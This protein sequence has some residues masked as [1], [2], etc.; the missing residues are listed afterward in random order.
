MPSKAQIAQPSGVVM[1]ARHPCKLA[2][3]AP[4]FQLGHPEPAPCSG[5]NSKSTSAPP[6]ASFTSNRSLAFPFA[7]SLHL[8]VL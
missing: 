4:H 1:L 5:V 8:G 7:N 6:L 3:R 2:G